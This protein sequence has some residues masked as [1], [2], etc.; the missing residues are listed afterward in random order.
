MRERQSGRGREGGRPE[1]VRESSTS[2][3][4]P[5][6]RN[7]SILRTHA[8]RTLQERR[9]AWSP[10]E[11]EDRERRASGGRFLPMTPTA[12]FKSARHD[13]A[14]RTRTTGA[15]VVLRQAEPRASLR[16]AETNE[17]TK[18][19]NINGLAN[20]RS[21]NEPEPARSWLRFGPAG[22]MALPLQRGRRRPGVAAPPARRRARSSCQG[23][24]FGHADA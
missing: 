22:A 11:P 4:A 2:R 10:N 16:C 19:A 21:E 14:E 3:T 20:Y 6:Q 13:D 12:F 8:N 23:S 17:P 15:M 1:V 24:L 9:A 5:D 7:P 18:T